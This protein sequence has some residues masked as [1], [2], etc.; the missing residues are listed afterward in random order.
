MPTIVSFQT[1]VQNTSGGT[2]FFGF[3][4]PHGRELSSSAT[5]TFDGNLLSLLAASGSFSKERPLASLKTC[6]DSGYLCVKRFPAP[7]LWDA[8]LNVPQELKVIDDASRWDGVEWACGSSS[9]RASDGD[10]PDA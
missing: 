6:L 10:W 9:S 1:E 5:Y 3:I 7:I 8:T 2:M 4:P